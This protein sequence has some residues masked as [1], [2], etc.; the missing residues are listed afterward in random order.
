MSI[1]ASGNNL[2]AYDVG[3]R[4]SSSSSSRDTIQRWEIDPIT[5]CFNNSPTK[6]LAY[7]D[8]ISTNVIDGSMIRIDNTYSQGM[9][10]HPTD[11]N[12]LYLT[13]TFNA[14]V[15]K[16]TLNLKKDNATYEHVDLG[17]SISS[18]S[19]PMAWI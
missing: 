4:L 2:Y 7:E 10:A 17:S 8:Q 6:T 3:S 14:L 18:K 19:N 13:D 5:K 12:I 16:P 1:D 11:D 9:E 15:Y